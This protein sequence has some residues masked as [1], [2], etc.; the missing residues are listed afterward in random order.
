MTNKPING[1]MNAKKEGHSKPCPF[2]I[3][4]NISLLSFQVPIV[5]RY[6]I[7]LIMQKK[8]TET[9]GDVAAA[10]DTKRYSSASKYATISWCS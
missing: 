2:L 3:T 9:L 8:S 4:R 6:S 1:N 5:Q 7:N 10:F